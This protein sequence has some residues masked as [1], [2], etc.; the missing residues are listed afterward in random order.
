VELFGLRQKMDE[1]KEQTKQFE[2]QIENEKAELKA[3]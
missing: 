2:M 1:W 3:V